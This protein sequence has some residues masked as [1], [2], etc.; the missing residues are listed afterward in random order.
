[1]QS[2]QYYDREENRNKLS[3]KVHITRPLCSALYL[4][5]VCGCA[6]GNT[7]TPEGVFHRTGIRSLYSVEGRPYHLTQCSCSLIFGLDFRYLSQVIIICFHLAY[8]RISA[9]WTN[10]KSYWLWVFVSDFVLS[11]LPSCLLRRRYVFRP[12]LGIK[13][14]VQRYLGIYPVHV[15]PV[16]RIP[17][18]PRTLRK[19]RLYP[20]VFGIVLSRSRTSK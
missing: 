20:T 7:V 19:N 10:R 17:Q 12:V 18:I 11:F 4:V 8:A 13:L 1:M 5:L 9:H 14:G 16:V 6:I 15:C 2:E 3:R